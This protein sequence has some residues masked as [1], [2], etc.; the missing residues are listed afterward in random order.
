[1]KKENSTMKKSLIISFFIFL[2][3]ISSFNMS[4][5]TVTVTEDSFQQSVTK[6][7]DPNNTLFKMDREN[8]TLTGLARN[9]VIKYNFDNNPTFTF[10][11]DF[12][13]E[14]TEQQCVAKRQCISFLLSMFQ[15]VSDHFEIDENVA[16]SYYVDKTNSQEDVKK[17]TE[18]V[19]IGSSIENFTNAIDYAKTIFD[20][21]VSF[22]DY[23]FTIESRKIEET[24]DNYKAQVVFTVNLSGDFSQMNNSNT[25]TEDPIISHAQNAL[26][27]YKNTAE[28]ENQLLQEYIDSMNEK[29]NTKDNIKNNSNVSN[30]N[31]SKNN[32]PQTGITNY[33]EI[34]LVL[35]VVACVIFTIKFVNY[36]KD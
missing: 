23:L 22:S 2:V 5:A 13:K 35:S 10:D 1:M 34:L 16:R 17:L 28:K 8:D 25:D 33:I 18:S 26:N 21:N 36:K 30:K 27:E 32:L 24:A 14:M 15:V 6:I 9:F 19:L 4:F 31:T 3:L 20:K 29:N 7:L 12:N 11:F